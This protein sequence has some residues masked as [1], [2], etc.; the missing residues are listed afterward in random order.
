MHANSRSAYPLEI[1]GSVVNMVDV[2]FI[3]GWIEKEI[4]EFDRDTDTARQ[5]LVTG[6]HGLNQANK[7]PHYFRIGQ[8][9]DLWVP[10]SIAPVLV[11]RYRGMKQAVRTPGAEIM[12][13]YFRLADARGFSSFFYG[14]SESTLNVLKERLETKYPGHRI[15][16]MFSPPF[17]PL[18]E[19]EE[20]AH[21]AMINAAA[22]DVL[23]VGLGMPKQ[24]EWIYRCRP[25]LKVPV[26]AGVGAAFGFTADTVRRAPPW[27]CRIGLEWAYMVLRKPKR[28]GRRV[29]VEGSEFLW[30]LLKEEVRRTGR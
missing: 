16:G 10:D 21:V 26:A 15:A 20:R 9:C 2:P 13:A 6:F 23:W 8:A 7:D 12:A 14:D 5:I 22:P 19:Q 24:D 30:H 17:R 3:I 1:L 18:T 27:L 25:G 11:A 4:R 29:L 28:T